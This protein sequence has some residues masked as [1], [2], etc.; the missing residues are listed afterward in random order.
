MGK[1]C[2]FSEW[3]WVKWEGNVC[4]GEHKKK[5]KK[6]VLIHPT[7]SVTLVQLLPPRLNMLRPV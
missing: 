1:V 3:V 6:T 7:F 5:T 2:G 4:G